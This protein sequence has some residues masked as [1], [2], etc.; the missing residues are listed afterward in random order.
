MEHVYQG[1]LHLPRNAGLSAF[2][3]EIVGTS[4]FPPILTED[5]WRAVC[6]L[7]ADESRIK[8]RTNRLRWMLVGLARCYCG[9]TVRSATA[10]DRNGVLRTIYRCR[11]AGSGHVSRNAVDLD[12]YIHKAVI[13]R[14]SGADA[15]ALLTVDAERPDVE[16]LRTEAMAL[17]ARLT[18][19]ADMYA[20][21]EISRA[22]LERI[23]G[24]VYGQLE[25]VEAS[26]AAS[27]E[28]T[29]LGPLIA[30]ENPEKVWQRLNV[31]RRRA[32]VDA[33]MTVT[34]LPWDSTQWSRTFHPEL[35]RIEWRH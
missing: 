15:A 23:T 5:T 22:Q 4:T 34:L 8:S 11:A 31:E 14:L 21:G 24:R 19:A 1:C 7:L 12:D 27:A 25:R 13:M 26:L 33:L 18:E 20:T 35:V 17:R 10:S 29:T 9:E 6:R 2:H 32:V 16:A 3:G 28:K 30:T